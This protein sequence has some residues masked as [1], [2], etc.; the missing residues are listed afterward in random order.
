MV[1]AEPLQPSPAEGGRGSEDS[2]TW[3]Y[4]GCGYC[5]RSKPVALFGQ[6]GDVPKGIMDV[7]AAATAQAK[8]S[9]TIGSIL[10][11]CICG[12]N[13]IITSGQRA[14]ICV[15]DATLKGAQRTT[16]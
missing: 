1:H 14:V 4:L 12:V 10:R 13:K 8:E 9:K 3:P 6:G 16:T 15:F 2:L 5:G 11:H 7:E